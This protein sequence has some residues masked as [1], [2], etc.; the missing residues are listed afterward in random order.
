MKKIINFLK[1]VKIELKNVTWPNRQETI[2]Y[3]A[4]VVAGSLVVAIILGGFDL[5][6]MELLER[7]VI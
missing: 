6:F 7:I 4:I 1:E 5:I 3:T 2:K